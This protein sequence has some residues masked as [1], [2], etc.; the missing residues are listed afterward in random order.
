MSGFNILTQLSQNLLQLATET[1]FPCKPRLCPLHRQAHR[2]QLANLQK[3]PQLLQSHLSMPSPQI[4]NQF[5]T[6]LDLFA[7][8]ST[9]DLYFVLSHHLAHR[10]HNPPQRMPHLPVRRFLDLPLHRFFKFF[11]PNINLLSHLRRRVAYLVTPPALDELPILL[12]SPA[13]GKAAGRD[14]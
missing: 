9:R 13:L 10:L 2:R 3:S 6:P 7:P 4:A 8:L 11:I 5:A 12:N 14:R 1:R